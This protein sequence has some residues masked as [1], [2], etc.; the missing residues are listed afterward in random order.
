MRVWLLPVLGWLVARLADEGEEFGFLVD[1]GR[2]APG[3]SACGARFSSVAVCDAEFLF[4]EVGED[5]AGVPACRDKAETG[6]RLLKKAQR[7]ATAGT[8]PYLKTNRDTVLILRKLK[9]Q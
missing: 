4:G 9:N 8:Q 2:F 5:V 6:A 3:S 1:A 7:P